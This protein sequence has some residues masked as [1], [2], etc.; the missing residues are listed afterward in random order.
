MSNFDNKASEW[1]KKERRVKLASDVAEGMIKFGGIKEGD[2]VTDFGTGTGLILLK[3]S[4]IAGEMLGLDSSEK[5]LEVL[6][7]KA[8]SAGIKNLKT[9]LFDIEQ[10]NFEPESTYF[11]VASMVTHHLERPEMF[12]QKAYD[13]LKDGGKLCFADLAEEDGSFHDNADDSVKHHGFTES[14]VKNTLNQSRFKNIQ[15][16]NI[17]EVE[18]ERKDGIKKFPVFLAIGEK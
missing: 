8:K 16:H 2:S 9:K 6:N 13:A 18:K 17:T 1:D 7:E 12:I 3:I 15:F 10:D 11:L 5:M 4:D 14:W